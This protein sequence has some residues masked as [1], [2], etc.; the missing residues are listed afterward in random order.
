GAQG[1]DLVAAAHALGP[2]APLTLWA[3]SRAISGAGRGRDYAAQ[4]R[5]A[6]SALR[7]QINQVGSRE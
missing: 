5:E 6:A 4:A 1:G 2:S 3:A 7:H